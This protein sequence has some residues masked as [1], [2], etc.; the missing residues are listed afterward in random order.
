MELNMKGYSPIFVIL[1]LLGFLFTSCSSS[2][3]KNA[4]SPVTSTAK[5]IPV[6]VQRPLPTD[7]PLITDTL[8]PTLTPTRTITP[9]TPVDC[10]RLLPT[11]SPAIPF[12]GSVLF[13]YIGPDA[14]PG[15]WGVSAN[16]TEAHVVFKPVLPANNQVK[17]SPDGSKIAWNDF[18]QTPETLVVDDLATQMET[19]YP[20]SAYWKSLY[21]WTEDNRVKIYV[22]GRHPSDQVGKGLEDTYAYFDLRTGSVETETIKIDLPEY[23]FMPNLGGGSSIDPRGEVVLYTAIGKSAGNDI[24]LMNIKTGQILWSQTGVDDLIFPRPDWT[25]DGSQVLFAYWDL[26]DQYM[27][28]FVLSRDGQQLKQLKDTSLVNQPCERIRS[29]NWLPDERYI[30]YTMRCG[31]E[32]PAFILDTVTTEVREICTP[33]YRFVEGM[34]SPDSR[35]FVYVLR[36][37]EDY[38]L[39]GQYELHLLDMN[40]WTTQNI[41]VSDELGKIRFD[42]LGWT[43]LTFP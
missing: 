10:P 13:T 35:Q 1:L 40:T 41:A 24:I 27:K 18:E 39:G 11:D 42:I 37:G 29:M 5:A 30:Y 22:S 4:A 36:K 14:T 33:G 32:G 38:M 17:L 3:G 2:P 12:N 43:P 19:R 6:T 21:G 23:D 26:Q 28:I 34:W 16:S 8:T 25:I 7:F 20:W 9:T 15:V 31:E